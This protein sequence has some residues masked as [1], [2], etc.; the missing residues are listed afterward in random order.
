MSTYEFWGDTVQAIMLPK[1]THLGSKVSRIQYQV[2]NA[3]AHNII[4]SSY[5]MGGVGRE[6]KEEKEKRET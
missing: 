5:Y 1:V 2:W 3:R 4:L 6:R